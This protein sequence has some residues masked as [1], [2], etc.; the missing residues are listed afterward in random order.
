MRPIN[1]HGRDAM[2][3]A[4]DRTDRKA[5]QV[6]EPGFDDSPSAMIEREFARAGFIDT[7]GD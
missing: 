1:A 6:K 4:L 2:M 7:K 5:K 3:K